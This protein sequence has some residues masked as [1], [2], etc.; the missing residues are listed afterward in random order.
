MMTLP[1]YYT[2][3]HILVIKL[4]KEIYLNDMASHLFCGK[5][6]EF[7]FN[8]W[9][10]H[11][12]DCFILWCTLIDILLSISKMNFI[13]YRRKQWNIFVPQY[14]TKDDKEK[15]KMSRLIFFFKY[16]YSCGPLSTFQFIFYAS[17]G[18]KASMNREA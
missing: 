1:R 7:T 17:S 18:N 16:Y 6:T 8:K 11:L 4:G 14:Y 13:R 9:E 10:E 12:Q 5:S 15:N 2:L 3:L